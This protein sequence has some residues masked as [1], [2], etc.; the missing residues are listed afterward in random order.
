MIAGAVGNLIDR[1]YLRHEVDFIYFELI[2]FPLFNFADSCLTVASIL[3]FILAIFY[4]KDEDFEFLNDL[5]KKKTVNHQIESEDENEDENEDD[6]S[7]DIEEEADD[8]SDDT[9]E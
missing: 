3:L 6:D 9:I 2:D 5:F 7:F 1:F 4:Y 8:D